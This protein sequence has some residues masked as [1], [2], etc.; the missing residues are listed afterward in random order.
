MAMIVTH[1]KK[2]SEEHSHSH[3]VSKTSIFFFFKRDFFTIFLSQPLV[4]IS[5]AL[6]KRLQELIM[7][8]FIQK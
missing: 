2:K 7:P 6:F 5:E 3:Y 1:G 8:I 4:H